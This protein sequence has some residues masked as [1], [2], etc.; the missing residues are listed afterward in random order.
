MKSKI[1]LNLVVRI[2]KVLVPLILA[3]AAVVAGFGVYSVRHAMPQTTADV[4]L[5]SLV[6]RVEVIR[7]RFGVP[8]I[9]AD[10]PEDLFRAQGF[11]H[12][13]DRF[14]QMEFWRRIGQGRL[15]ELLGK[16]TLG[17]DRFIRTVGWNRSAARDAATLTPEARGVLDAYADGLN[18]YV[19]PRSGDPSSLALEFRILRLINTLPTIEPWQPVHSLGWAKVMAWE[20]RGDAF[21]DELDRL[22]IFERGGQPLLD[23]LRPAYPQDMPVIVPSTVA[24]ANPSNGQLDAHAPVDS[25]AL[26]ELRDDV[27]A[28]DALIGHVAGHAIGSNNWVVAGS[29]TSTGKPLLANDPHLSIQMP[30]IATKSV[31]IVVSS[32]PAARMIWLARAS[33]GC[34]AW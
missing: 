32:V 22:A 1:L 8:H 15:S 21:D 19:Q 12:A 6:G 2:A 33:P 5:P 23:A 20:L 26:A 10:T 30:S 7:D 25:R 3:I 24:A 18:Q 29:Q 13:Q 34:R 28:L 11:V 4:H 14:F 27:A 31:S 17:Q 16:S 9:Y